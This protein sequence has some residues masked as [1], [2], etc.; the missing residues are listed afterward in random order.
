[1]HY[2]LC[3]ECTENFTVPSD[4]D[5][6]QCIYCGGDIL[7]ISKSDYESIDSYIGADDYC[8]CEDYPCCIHG[9]E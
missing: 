9:G 8:V 3:T 1:M 4:Y 6:D 5:I 2:L 7:Y